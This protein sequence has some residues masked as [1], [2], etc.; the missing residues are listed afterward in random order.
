MVVRMTTNTSLLQ[1]AIEKVKSGDGEVI[2]DF[3]SVSRIDTGMVRELEEL[4]ALAAARSARVQL[5]AVNADIYRVLKQLKLAERFCFLNRDQT[6]GSQPR[7][8]G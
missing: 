1:E 5:R 3:A 7:R 6:K 8:S 4:S 2:L